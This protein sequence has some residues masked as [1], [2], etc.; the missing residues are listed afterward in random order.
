MFSSMGY[1][2]TNFNLNLGNEFNTSKVTSMPSMF[3]NMGYS[4]TN[5]SLNLGDKFNM[6]NVKN[7][8]NMFYYTGANAQTNF[9]IDLSAGNF[10]KIT[11]AKNYTNMFNGFPTA[12]GTI[13]VKDTASQSWIINKNSSWGTNFSATNVLVKGS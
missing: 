7:A 1:K 2:A 3:S 11:V 8:A 5:F 4:A 9:D 13:Y 12:Y 10:D 6:S